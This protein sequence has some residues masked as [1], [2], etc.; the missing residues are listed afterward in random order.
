MARPAQP[1]VPSEPLIIVDGHTPLVARSPVMLDAIGRPLS[2]RTTQLELV[3]KPSDDAPAIHNTVG[4]SA[5]DIGGG[6]YTLAIPPR[7]L[8]LRLAQHA[9]QRVWLRTRVLGYPPVY[10]PMM[11]VWRAAEFPALVT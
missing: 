11:V 10:T 3:A 7:S 1:I 2:G 5:V 4:G 8:W 9:N 6:S